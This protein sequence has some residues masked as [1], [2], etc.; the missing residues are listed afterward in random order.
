MHELAIA[1]S[2]LTVV[3]GHAGERRVTGVWLKVGHLRQVVPSALEF[4]FELV[5]EGTMA[6]GATLEIESIS[7]AGEC[8][9][10]GAQSELPAFPLTCAACGSFDVNVIRGEELVVDSVEIDDAVMAQA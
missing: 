1:D 7:A 3:L 5:C 8:R 2:V 4:S 10:C 6:E 9:M